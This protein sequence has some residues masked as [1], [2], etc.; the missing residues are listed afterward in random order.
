MAS[1]EPIVRDVSTASY[2]KQPTI[3][4]PPGA[5]IARGAD[6]WRAVHEAAARHSGGRPPVIVVDTYPGVD[7]TALIRQLEAAL[8]HYEIIN[9]E[10]EAALP[11]GQIDALIEGNL[12]DDRVF[13]VMS[14]ATLD[15]FY[16][17]GRL[18]SLA[19][20]GAARRVPTVLVG[21]GAALA[22]P[23]P[24]GLVLVDMARWELQLR[25]RAGAPNWRSSNTAED[26]LR[27]YK[28][29]FFVEWRMADRH[30]R[31]LFD[32]LDFVVD[33][34]ADATDAAG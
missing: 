12:T 20:R 11:I 13:G 10:D 2:V 29:G 17:A 30:K 3:A 21:W 14:H 6:A 16:D 26:N 34:N 9:V 1:S 31:A 18:A 27:K 28:R 23:E 8:P 15:G 25:Q 22:A 19:E 4:L 24:D 5:E 33:G 32:S 7:L